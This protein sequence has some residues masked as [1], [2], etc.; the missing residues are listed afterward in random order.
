MADTTILFVYGTLKRGHRNHHRMTGQRY[1]GEVVTVP[2]YRLV[3][4]GP[5]PGLVRDEANG[6]AVRGELWEVSATTLAAL[7]EFEMTT[8]EYSR[9]EVEIV[10]FADV[11]AYYFNDPPP[12]DAPTGAV[13]PMG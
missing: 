13:W 2:K 6:L 11:Q 7:D 12:S 5:Y 9:E 1:L 4:L 8:D 10:G 3:D